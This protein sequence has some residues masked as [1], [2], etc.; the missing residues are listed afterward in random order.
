LDTDSDN[1]T[2]KKLENIMMYCRKHDN[3][4]EDED[5]NTATD[6]GVGNNTAMDNVGGNGKD[7]DDYYVP[8][9]G[10]VDLLVTPIIPK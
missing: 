3:D 1:A 8:G 5:N 9:N 2:N 10:Q 6:N 7:D 4:D